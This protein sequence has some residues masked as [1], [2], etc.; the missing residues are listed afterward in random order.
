MQS[1]PYLR[2][3]FFPKSFHLALGVLGVPNAVA[4]DLE[5][6]DARDGCILEGRIDGQGDT[7]F[8]PLPVQ[9]LLSHILSGDS[10]HGLLRSVDITQEISSSSA[11]EICHKPCNWG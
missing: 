4:V 7:E 2:N 10:S 11:R 3:Q 1:P 8:G 6:L 9:P 5:E